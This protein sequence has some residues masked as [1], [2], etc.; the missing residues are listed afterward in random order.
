LTRNLLSLGAQYN[1][2]VQAAQKADRIVQAKVNNWGKAI[3]MLSRPTT[4]I[5]AHLPQMQQ[6]EPNYEAIIELLTDLRV[7]LEQLETDTA[8]SLE[9][10]RQV[11]AF[12]ESDDISHTLLVKAN[13]LTQGSPIV[14]LEPEQF[15]AEFEQHLNAY[16][17]YQEQIKQHIN[18]QADL[19]RVIQDL[20]AQFSFVV[21]SKTILGKR[22]KAITNLESAFIKFKEIRTNLVEGI[23]VIT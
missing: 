6:D 2:T 23:K 17:T 16:K 21:T 11:V 10:Q 7:K 12:S 13:A 4:E 5:Q 20:H 1:D 15:S 19:L 8:Q 9:M 18:T 14:K 3:A 22:E